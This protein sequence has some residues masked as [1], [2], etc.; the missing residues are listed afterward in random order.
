MS[1]VLYW[2]SI[3]S[4]Y[5]I[6]V[7]LR[8]GVVTNE[9]PSF[10]SWLD[11]QNPDTMFM[12]DQARDWSQDHLFACHWYIEMDPNETPPHL[13]ELRRQVEPAFQRPAPVQPQGGGRVSGVE[14]ALGRAPKPKVRA[15]NSVPA[16]ALTVAPIGR[17][18]GPKTNKR[19]ATKPLVED[20]TPKRGKHSEQDQDLA[21]LAEVNQSEAK[22]S[23]SQSHTGR[24][25][26]GGQGSLLRSCLIDRAQHGTVY[27]EHLVNKP[28][29]D[30]LSSDSAIFEEFARKVFIF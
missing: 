29:A 15:P 9:H 27:H 12:S 19:P 24:S 28:V 18:V 13:V 23:R 7:L 5:W 22:S 26:G 4:R 14:V 11:I 2:T 1:H 25:F 16:K 21:D 30:F 17:E 3:I 10:A 6:H 20:E 8:E